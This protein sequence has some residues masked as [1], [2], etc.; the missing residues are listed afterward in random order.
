[1]NPSIPTVREALKN[2]LANCYRPR[3]EVMYSQACV[4][5]S[6]QLGKGGGGG[7]KKGNTRCIMIGHR[8]VVCPRGEREWTPNPP[9]VSGHYVHAGGTRPSGLHSC[10]KLRFYKIFTKTKRKDCIWFQ[11][12]LCL[13]YRVRARLTLRDVTQCVLAPQT[14][15]QT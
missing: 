12:A 7:G 4:T 10:L 2:I 8:E 11:Q 5:H 13:L 1:M 3:S 14:Q 6:V 9:P 15:I